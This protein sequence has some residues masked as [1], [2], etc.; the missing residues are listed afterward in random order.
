MS[1]RKRRS[2]RSASAQ[3]AQH[4]PPEDDVVIRRSGEWA[5]EL[6]MP[7]AR[8]GRPVKPSQYRDVVSE[9][10]AD[11]KARSRVVADR[12]AARLLRKRLDRAAAGMGG[13]LSTRTEPL[14]DGAVKLVFVVLPRDVVEETG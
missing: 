7:E 11:G 2:S 8:R 5:E 6:S 12:R 1:D 13:R 14:P 10:L 9:C 3:V 4:T